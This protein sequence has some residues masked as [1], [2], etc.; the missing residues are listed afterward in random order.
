MED[1]KFFICK[2]TCGTHSWHNDYLNLDNIPFWCR[3]VYMDGYHGTPR[4][5]SL[6]Q[7]ED[8]RTHR[9]IRGSGYVN[10]TNLIPLK[11]K[12]RL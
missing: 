3:L 1:S 7:R 11:V 10:M 9:A 6:L 8:M 4:F 12:R 2:D 5:V